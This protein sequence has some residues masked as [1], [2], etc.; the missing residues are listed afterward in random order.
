MGGGSGKI[1]MA[2]FPRWMVKLSG[3]YQLPLDFNVSATFNAREGHIIPWS[4]GLVNYDAPNSRDTGTTMLLEKFGKLRMPNFWNLN[5][6]VE[7]VVRA[8][9]YGRIYLMAD[10]FNL[11]NMA[12][13]NR[14]YD[15]HHGTYYFHSD[16]VSTNATDYQLNEI[17]NPRIVR[18]GIRFQY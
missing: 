17:L 1:S 14:R 9:D 7:K 2:V 12:H 6:R 15:K 3:L 18:F 16:S 8:G 11:F 13:E 5:L 4:I 10:I